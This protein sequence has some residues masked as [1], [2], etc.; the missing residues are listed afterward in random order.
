MKHKTIIIGIALL[1]PSAYLL[2]DGQRTYRDSPYGFTFLYPSSWRNAQR[3]IEDGNYLYKAPQI[4]VLDLTV[5]NT[6]ISPE[7]LAKNEIAANPCVDEHGGTENRIVRRNA[8][9]TLFVTH[10]GAST[11]VYHYVFSVGRGI[12][13]SLA[14]HDDF[15]SGWAEDRKL[16]RLNEIIGSI[17]TKRP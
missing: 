1:L 9:G 6:T 5:I 15:D 8:R 2:H 13:V 12:I 10:C 3:S 16:T 14:Y 4:D 11:E 7:N 17:Q